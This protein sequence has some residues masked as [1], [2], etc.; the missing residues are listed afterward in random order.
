M[1]KSNKDY[2]DEEVKEMFKNAKGFDPVFGINKEYTDEEVKEIF[3]NVPKIK[4]NNKK[5][6]TK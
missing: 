2:T 5:E 4:D 1:I 3:A 6:L